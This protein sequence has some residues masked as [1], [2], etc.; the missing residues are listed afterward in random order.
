M[1]KEEA[2]NRV[3]NMIYYCH[4]DPC[5][6]PRKCSSCEA[7]EDNIKACSMAQ[8]KYAFSLFSE[9]D[10]FKKSITK[11]EVIEK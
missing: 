10:E 5:P 9:I 6:D 1:T 8:A 4:K 7:T 2:L 11:Q 3:A